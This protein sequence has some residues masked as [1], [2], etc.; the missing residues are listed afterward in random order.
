MRSERSFDGMHLVRL[1]GENRRTEEPVFTFY[2]LLKV[3][4]YTNLDFSYSS[5]NK[6]AQEI[7]RRDHTDHQR[8]YIESFLLYIAAHVFPP[9]LGQ[10]KAH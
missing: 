8:R 1:A 7:Q 2:Y 6:E 9:V 10:N 3:V 4:D 5:L